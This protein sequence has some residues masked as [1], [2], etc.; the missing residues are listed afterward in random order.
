MAGPP[1]LCH[2]PD[3]CTPLACSVTSY[4][5]MNDGCSPSERPGAGFYLLRERNSSISFSSL[6]DQKVFFVC[7]SLPEK[8]SRRKM[9]AAV[10]RHFLEVDSR[11]ATC[12]SLRFTFFAFSGSS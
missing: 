8:F 11:S 1:F 7:S 12:E 10:F 2:P 4:R 9:K 5:L 6:Q 3:W